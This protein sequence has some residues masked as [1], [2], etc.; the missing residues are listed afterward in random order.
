M[1]G[2]GPPVSPCN[3]EFGPKFEVHR[4]EVMPLAAPNEAVFF[5]DRD[6]LF[7]HAVAITDG[8]AMRPPVPIIREG[9]IEIDGDAVAVRARL[10]GIRDGSA[11]VSPGDRVCGAL[12]I[13]RQRV[14]LGRHGAQM[15]ID[16]VQGRDAD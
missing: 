9:R 13:F 3:K 12:D 1:R 11:I 5:E 6:D 15:L 16:A 14:D 10:A 7:V 2:N 4:I 8:A